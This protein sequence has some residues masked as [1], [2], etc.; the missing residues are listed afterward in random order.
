MNRKRPHC[1]TCSATLRPLLCLKKLHANCK[2]KLDNVRFLA[3]WRLAYTGFVKVEMSVPV[4]MCAYAS[5]P[6]RVGPSTNQCYRP[7]HGLHSNCV[8]DQI[9]ILSFLKLNHFQLLT[10]SFS[11]LSKNS[12]RSLK[13][14]C[15]L[16][17]CFA[18]RT[19]K[20][21][22]YFHLLIKWCKDSGWG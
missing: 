6:T 2:F 15:N 4:C 19:A 7:D 10:L 1:L 3:K 21:D 16:M 9:S 8:A 5:I 14:T 17:T 20:S 22:T 13:N 18:I 12:P 11:F